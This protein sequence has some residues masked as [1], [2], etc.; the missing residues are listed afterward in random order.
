MFPCL[1]IVLTISSCIFAATVAEDSSS[2]AVVRVHTMAALRSRRIYG[3]L[4]D[5]GNEEWRIKRKILESSLLDRSTVQT[6]HSGELVKW[7]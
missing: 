7:A 4:N 2:L 6:F 5:H 3:M 1:S